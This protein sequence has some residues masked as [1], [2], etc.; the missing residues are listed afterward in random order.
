VNVKYLTEISEL[1]HFFLF[2]IDGPELRLQMWSRVDKY[3]DYIQGWILLIPGLYTGMD[4]VNTRIIYVQ[5]RQQTQNEPWLD[6]ALMDSAYKSE[7]FRKFQMTLLSKRLMF[8]SQLDT[9]PFKPIIDQKRVNCESHMPR[10]KRR[11]IWNYVFS[12]DS[13]RIWGSLI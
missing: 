12:H 13:K 3:Q 9:V 6:Q 7:L 1:I 10:F 4:T 8:K 11:A 5:N 2:S